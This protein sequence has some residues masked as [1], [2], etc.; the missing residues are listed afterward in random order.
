MELTIQSQPQIEQLKEDLGSAFPTYK[1][2]HPLLSK[3]IINVVNGLSMVIITT[4]GDKIKI[5]SGINIMKPWAFVVFVLLFALSLIGGL[6]FYA[7]LYYTKKKDMKAL[8]EEVGNYISDK[9]NTLD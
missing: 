9:Y 5:G 1:V 8:E 3:K 6:I 2:K 7:I 4:K